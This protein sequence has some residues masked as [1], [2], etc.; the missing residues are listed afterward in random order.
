[1]DGWIDE[2]IGVGLGAGQ[3]NGGGRTTTDLRRLVFL[4]WPTGLSTSLLSANDEAEQW[5]N[6]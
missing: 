3:Q 4:A 6:G 5:R 1:M 2:S